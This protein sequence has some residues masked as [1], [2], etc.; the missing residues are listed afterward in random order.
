MVSEQHHASDR[1]HAISMASQSVQIDHMTEAHLVKAVSALAF[2]A[3]GVPLSIPGSS[4]TSVVYGGGSL[5]VTSGGQ[6]S[7][8]PMPTW[9]QV[10][11]QL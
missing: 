7:S 9:S 5:N 8:L 3:A 2:H 11:Y 6:T 4:G 10:S 1:P